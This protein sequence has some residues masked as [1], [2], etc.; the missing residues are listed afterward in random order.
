[1][2]SNE[3]MDEAARLW[4][5][6]MQDPSFDD[7]DG[8]TAWLESHPAHLA[9]YEHV[10]AADDWA[11][12]LFRTPP[13]AFEPAPAP[14]AGGPPRRRWAWPAM[15]GLLAASLALLATWTMLGHDGGAQEFVTGPGEHRTIALADGSQVVLNGGTRI[16]LDPR[17]PRAVALAQG[18]ALF[19]VR[20]DEARPFVV[21]ANGATLLDAGTMFNVVSQNGA[22]RVAVAE[23]AVIYQP[24]PG[25]VRLDP[26]DALSVSARGARPVVSR[27]SRAA[28]GSWQQRQLLYDDAT[29][30]DV[31]L[32][33]ARNIGQPVRVAGDA[34]RM[35][36]TGA[37]MLGDT[38]RQ[39][40]DRAGPLLGVRFE[41]RGDVW[42]M[43]PTHAM[44]Q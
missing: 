24:G 27:V 1:M 28:V 6:R 18:E 36:F 20:H 31:A 40:L 9:R 7:W 11:Q 5:I 23:G 10:L 26:G 8:F 13:S 12:D 4:A 38:P 17:A 19:T 43:T 25:Q 15:G 29:L 35:R 2:S 39:T 3:E 37:L 41:A 22:M 33:L 30:D 21:T 34:G 16:S 44:S 42:T 14:H 32:D